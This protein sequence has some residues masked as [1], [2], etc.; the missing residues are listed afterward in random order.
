[1]WWF[2]RLAAC[3]TVSSLVAGAQL[4]PG[5]TVP[6]LIGVYLDFASAPESVSIEVMKR[7]VEILLQ[8]AD[9]T[10]AWRSVR[11]NSGTEAFSALAVL[12]FSGRCDARA[13]KP[14]NGFGTLGEV[15]RLASTSVGYGRV[16]PYAEVECD[17]VRKAL[18][19]VAPGAGLRARQQ[20]LGLALGRVVAHELYHILGNTAAHARE[21]LA[22]ASELFR[23]LAS[24]GEMSFDD[25][26]A[27]MIRERLSV[28]K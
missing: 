4:P 26:A 1:M 19:Y 8:P 25:G 10:L 24:G 6:P 21:G 3:A 18:A 7:S 20:A 15:D 11:G 13:P 12:K 9:V 28:G 27:S 17:Q 2:I 23:D 16:L 14:T 5:K 22:Q